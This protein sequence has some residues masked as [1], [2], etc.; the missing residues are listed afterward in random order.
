[1]NRSFADGLAHLERARELHTAQGELRSAAHAQARSGRILR[2][3]GRL[4]EAAAVLD[5]ALTVLRPEPD[6]ATVWTLTEASTVDVFSAGTKGMALAD[7]ALALGQAMGVR[8]TLLAEMFVAHGIAAFFVGRLPQATA[9][10]EYAAQVAERAG[11]SE[12]QARAL[13]NLSA[14]LVSMDAPAAIE[15]A[16]AACDLC[17]R[18]GARVSLG[19]A[20]S[21]LATAQLG[22]G[23]WAEAVQVLDDAVDVDGLDDEY[24]LALRA[25]AA[26]LRGDPDTAAQF[27]EL[28]VLRRSD[29]VQD[30]GMVAWVDAFI[31]AAAGQPMQVLARARE[32]FARK[33]ELDA[34]HE[35][36]FWTWPLGVRTAFELGDLEAVREF[37]AIVDSD[38]VGRRPPIVQAEAALAHARL[39]AAD[40]EDIDAFTAAIDQLRSVGSP[41]HL[42]Q[43]LLD[44]ADE[45]AR[46]GL[47]REALVDE[48]VVIAQQLGA[49]PLLARA[50]G[51]DADRQP[52]A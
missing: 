16:Q 24:V 49:A 41:Y 9:V 23:E 19:F 3:L 18:T 1:M 33:S 36:F 10:L 2:L 5:E 48:A 40:G 38:P 29:D 14:V 7:E 50:T 45:R 17:R 43:G 6:V 37:L 35:A 52:T 47:D 11:D 42:A 12:T 26:A 34:T 39:A 25:V 4:A 21:N 8:G 30:A 46:R 20:I 22:T 27:A 28:P 32:V 51:V 31:A 13:L 15:V 44:L